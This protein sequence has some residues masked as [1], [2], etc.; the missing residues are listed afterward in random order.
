MSL[1]THRKLHLEYEVLRSYTAGLV[2]R[3][4]EVKAIKAGNANVEG[5][6]VIVRGGEAYVVGLSIAPYQVANTPKD[7]DGIRTRKLLLNK[8]EIV[9][10]YQ[11]SENRGLTITLKSIYLSHGLIKCEVA[12]CKKLKKRDTREKIRQKDINKR[13]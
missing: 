7:Y 8:N 4:F 12:V 13:D 10:L 9:D 3:G 6:K 11:Y 5:S 1:A 2:L